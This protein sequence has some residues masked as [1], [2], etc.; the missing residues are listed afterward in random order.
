MDVMGKLVT[1]DIWLNTMPDIDSLINVSEAA[2]GKARMN[3]VERFRHSF[4]PH[5]DS[6]LWVLAE[7]HFSIHSFPEQKYISVDCY[8]CGQEGDPK[9][10]I[11]Y[12]TLLLDVN[13]I[14]I[15]VIDRGIY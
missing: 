12:F 15:N 6:L 1:A 10:C 8:T 13:R 5:G 2:I 14:K 9:S 11:N 4:N 7:S 3:I